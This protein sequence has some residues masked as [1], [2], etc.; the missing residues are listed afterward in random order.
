M[1]RADAVMYA[2]QPRL[3]ISK[4]EVNDWQELV[5]HLGISTFGNCV[6]VVAAFSQTSVA[7]PIVSNDQS[8]RNDSAVNE[9]TKRFSASVG[10]DGKTYPPRIASIPSL[11]LRGSRLP[12]AHLNGAGDQNL[13]VNAPT[14]TACPAADPAFVH[15]D[16][17]FRA[18]TDAVLVRARH[19]GAQLVEDLKSCLIPRDPKLALKLDS[20]HAG[21]LAGD[22]VGGP[23]PSG[24]RRVAAI[25]DRANRQPGL[26]SAFAACQHAWAG[27]D[28]E[29]DAGHPTVRTDKA[30]LPAQLFE[31][32]STSHI[33]REEPLEFWKRSRKRQRGMLIDVHHDRRRCIHSCVA[34]LKK[35][36]P[37]TRRIAG[38]LR[39]RL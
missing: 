26:T 27:R 20:R 5:R 30:V 17:L 28:A 29:R 22:Q 21:S 24:Q 13:V 38:V 12:M 1:L 31:I 32:R 36:S 6:V 16:M 25:H 37:L 10:D 19:S 4:D 7:T 18:A 34:R 3:E 39:Q 9:S 2:D 23:K 33:I 11:I 15:L 8:P 14:L 35:A